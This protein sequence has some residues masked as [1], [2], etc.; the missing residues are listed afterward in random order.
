[1]TS[2]TSS[3]IDTVIPI[4]RRIGEIMEE[5]GDAFSIRAF[6]ARIGMSKDMLSRCINGDRYLKPSELE[7]IAKGL[8]VS[9]ERI[10]QDDTKKQREELEVLLSTMKNPKRALE[11]SISLSQVAVGVTEK[12]STFNDLGRSY[13]FLK[14]I[15]E[16][17]HAWISAYTCAKHIAE[18]YGEPNSLYSVV[19]NITVLLTMTNKYIELI[20]FLGECENSFEVSPI[21]AGK[22]CYSHA[23]IAYKL[24][25]IVEAREFLNKSLQHFQ[26]TGN[27]R[28]IGKAEHTLACVEYKIG[29]YNE[30]KHLFEQAMIRLC[31]YDDVKFISIKDYIKT[32]LKLKEFPKA[33]E[34]IMNSLP[35]I[36]SK[37]ILEMKGLYLILLAIANNDPNSVET[38]L[39]MNDMPAYVKKLAFK[40][41]AYYYKQIDDCQLFM[42]YSKMVDQFLDTNSDILD[43][44][45]L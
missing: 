41:L 44:E 33:R 21:H 3:K 9:I 28:S 36:E 40:Y 34:L 31:P 39:D 10:K 12:C 14:M 8:G 16:A 2:T 4:G 26:L 5:K 24:G 6:A 42:K 30:S 17:Y 23:S 18:K 15:D 32:L 37:G 45:E 35:E 43:E 20:R 22:I 29:N 38:V 27:E 25:D 1:M 13:F 19:T 7:K 11:L